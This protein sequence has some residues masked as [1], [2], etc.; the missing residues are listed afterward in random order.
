MSSFI[1]RTQLT[2]YVEKGAGVHIKDSPV[3]FPSPFSWA[4]QSLV[5]G[6]GTATPRSARRRIALAAAAV[7]PVF[8]RNTNHKPVTATLHT[9]IG[10]NTAT[11][12]FLSSLP[13]HIQIISIRFQTIQ[14]AHAKNWKKDSLTVP[15]KFKK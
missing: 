8:C 12:L 2:P 1:C 15:V 3:F 10:Q 11:H 6:M 4:E 9:D 14:E 5:I 7:R 13:F